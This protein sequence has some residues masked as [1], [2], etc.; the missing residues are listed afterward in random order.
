MYEYGPG[1]RPSG[2]GSSDRRTVRNPQGAPD[3][4]E[5]RLCRLR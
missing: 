3:R 4:A 5:R 2:E 1:Q